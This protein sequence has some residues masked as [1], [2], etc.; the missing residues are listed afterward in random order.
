MAGVIELR[1]AIKKKVS[2]LNNRNLSADD[3]ITITNGATEGIY[4][5]IAA[6]IT[7]GHEVITF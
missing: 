4:S 6:L 3:E 5:T 2:L 1:G 7:T